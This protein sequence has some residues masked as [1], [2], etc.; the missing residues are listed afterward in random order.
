[1]AA[2]ISGIWNQ[3]ANAQTLSSAKPVTEDTTTDSGSNSGSSDSSTISANDFLTLL[4]TEMQNQDPTA[5]TDPNEYINQLVQVNSL[6]QLISINQTLTSDSTT[7]VSSAAGASGTG[8]SSPVLAETDA[9]TANSTPSSAQH[10]LPGT[11]SPLASGN[12]TIPK[13]D[14][15]AQRVAQALSGQ[16]N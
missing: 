11:A 7:A 9:A 3:V 16:H 13:T 15:A 6:E 4:V 8:Q 14:P 5:D 12:L 1:M 10:V 2:S